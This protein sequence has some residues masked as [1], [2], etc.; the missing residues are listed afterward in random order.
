MIDTSKLKKA[1]SCKITFTDT[2]PDDL[3]HTL[4]ET[5]DKIHLTERDYKTTQK[6]LKS[7][8]L[9]LPTLYNLNQYKNRTC[10]V[11]RQNKLA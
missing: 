8:G 11:F 3:V 7:A 4:Q 1:D 9:H 5:R 2:S 10:L 6:K